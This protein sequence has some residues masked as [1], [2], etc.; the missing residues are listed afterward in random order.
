MC[1]FCEERCCLF[2]LRWTSFTIG[3]VELLLFACITVISYFTLPESDLG[4]S[5]NMVQYGLQAIGF[6]CGLFLLLGALTVRNFVVF[7]APNNRL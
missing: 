6:V 7:G 2:P 3:V 1:D 4:K 5:H